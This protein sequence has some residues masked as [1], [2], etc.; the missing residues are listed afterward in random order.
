MCLCEVRGYKDLPVL[1]ASLGVGLLLAY[2]GRAR[3]VVRESD[4]SGYFYTPSVEHMAWWRLLAPPC[5]PAGGGGVC[6]GVVGVVMGGRRGG[7]RG[8]RLDEHGVY[9]ISG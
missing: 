6:Q 9:G 8:S 2:L 7:A 3:S 1:G 4:G 5:R